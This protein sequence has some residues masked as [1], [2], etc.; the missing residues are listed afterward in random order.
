MFLFRAFIF[1]FL[2]SDKNWPVLEVMKS[3][4]L[5]YRHAMYRVNPIWTGGNAPPPRVFVKYLKNDL[6]DLHGT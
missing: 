2:K 5:G 4:N 1:S 6:A 3:S